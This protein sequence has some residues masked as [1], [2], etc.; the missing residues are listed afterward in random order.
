MF[1]AQCHHVPC[2]QDVPHPGLGSPRLLWC[3]LGLLWWH[4]AGPIV[5]VWAVV[6]LGVPQLQCGGPTAQMMKETGSWWL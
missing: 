1:N 6:A 5:L 2:P 3:S 4:W